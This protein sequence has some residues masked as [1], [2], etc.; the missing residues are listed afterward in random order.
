MEKRNNKSCI[1][2]DSSSGIQ[3]GMI[4]NVYMIPLHIIKTKDGQITE[5][6]DAVDI[7]P[8]QLLTTLKE[9]SNVRFQSS[10]SA[11]G[12]IID[13]LEKLTKEYSTIYVWPISKGLSSSI[14]TWQM[15]AE[16]FPNCDINVI[17]SGHIN[18]GIKNNVEI[19]AQMIKENKSK[20][21][22]LDFAYANKDK[23][24]GVLVVNDLTELKKGGRINS[25]KALVATALKI[26]I[27]IS[28]NGKLEYLD[29]HKSFDKALDSVLDT[30]DSKNNFRKNG[31]KKVYMYTTYLDAA[32]NEEIKN[33]I[34]AKLQKQVED[35]YYF[36]AVIALHIGVG[37]YAI[38]IESN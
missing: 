1:I 4:E 8:E 30:I 26:N 3:N 15:A 27:L 28:Y 19:M 23:W 13:C 29:K 37:T 24:Y 14:F 33:A 10:Q 18:I 22:I 7:T 2:V 31:I 34:S 11:I 35:I 38:F 5:Y 17:D 32:K 16:E 21:E 36:P 12:E 6:K 20:Q 25:F 9:D